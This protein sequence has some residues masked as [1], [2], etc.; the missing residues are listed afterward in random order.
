MSTVLASVWPEGETDGIPTM[1]LALGDYGLYPLWVWIY[2]IV[3]WFV[4]DACKVLAWHLIIKYDVF[5]ARTARLVNLREALSIAETGAARASVGAVETKL[6]NRKID[7]ANVALD[8]LAKEDPKNPAYIPP[9]Q[10]GTA[11]IIPSLYQHAHSH[12]LFIELGQHQE[13]RR[14]RCVPSTCLYWCP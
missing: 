12:I 13:V 10:R 5:Q 2:C 11:P 4:Q 1:G 7:N 9:D 3:W 6:I 14:A 8:A